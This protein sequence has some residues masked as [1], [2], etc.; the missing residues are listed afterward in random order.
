SEALARIAAK[1]RDAVVL[2][3]RCYEQELVPFKA[4]DVLIDELS[5]VWRRMPDADAAALLPRHAAALARLFPVLGRVAAVAHAPSAAESRDPLEIRSRAFDALREVLQRLG[6]RR[7]VVMF[8]DDLQWVDGD[9]LTLL[10]E[11]LRPPEAPRV[12]L[13]VS[14]RSEAPARGLAE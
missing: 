6:D 10:E 9:T 2:R 1:H 7:L 3:G 4:M 12:L 8:L 13:L 14:T 11:L 5:R